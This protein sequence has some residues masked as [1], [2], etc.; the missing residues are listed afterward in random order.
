MKKHFLT[1][2]LCSAILLM[3]GSTVRAQVSHGGTPHYHMT[4][5][6]VKTEVLASINNDTYLQEDI[7]GNKMGTPMRVGVVQSTNITNTT[8]GTITT[9]AD[10][11]RV[12][13]MAVSSPNATFLNLHFS[14]FELPEGAELYFYNEPGTFV[15][16][17]FNAS[18]RL[19]E[20]NF[21]TQAIPGST[22]IIEYREPQA[23]A[24]QGRLTLSQVVH[25]YKDLFETVNNNTKGELG[26]AEGD[27]HINVAC[28][29]GDDWRKQIR[30]TVA[31]QLTAGY[32][33]FMCTGTVIN[34]T[35]RDRKPYVLTAY[36]CQDLNQY[37]GLNGMTFYFNYQASSCNG[38]TGATN[39]SI[40]GYTILAK[41]AYS[42]G[43]DFCLVQ[44]G[45]T[46]PLGYRAYYAGWDRNNV[47]SLTGAVCIHHPGGDIKK[48]SLAKSVTRLSG[49]YAN[50][51]Q[52]TWYS[53][54]DNKGVTEQGSSGSGLF[55]ADG[56]VVGQLFGGTSSC[57][58]INSNTSQLNDMYGRIYASWTGG[59]SSTTRLSDWLDPTGT[60]VTTLEGIDY[61][62]N[63]SIA[64]AELPSLQVYPNPSNG[65]VHINVSDLGNANYKV[66]DL[67]GR[68][69]FEGRTVLT[70]TVQSLNLNSLPAGTYRLLLYTAAN[71]YSQTIVITK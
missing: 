3:A 51:Y 68:C 69:L 40:T 15:L 23:V 48:I 7:L 21:Y 26:D 67:N 56:L 59:G 65:T 11:T 34:N 50:F 44:M 36:H 10:G 19:P 54:A 32:Y 2:A 4:K 45:S 25:G 8:H 58:Y 39:R 28:S 16:G 29:E 70:T 14:T 18:N 12:W 27:C 53:G 5:A 33:S 30:A 49:S 62:D 64:T 20:G 55:N 37:G 42:N 31:I 22:A 13:R 47:N 52:A 43:S 46:I 60:G 61:T 41:R 66:F 24:G 1:T 57:D 35:N 6:P 17:S 71:S 38:T 9:E 63:V